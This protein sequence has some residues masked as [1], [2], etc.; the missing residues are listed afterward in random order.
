MDKIMEIRELIYNVFHSSEVVYTHFRGDNYARYYTSMYLIAD[1]SEAVWT[2]MHG[3]FSRDPMRAYIEFWGVMQA[4][5]I[6]QDAICELHK[7]VVGSRPDKDQIGPAWKDLK[8]K[9]NL[10]AGHPAHRSHGVPAPQ[11]TFMGRSFG[12]YNGIK[13]ELWDAHTKEITHPVFDLRKMIEDYDLEASAILTNVLNNMR[14]LTMDQNG[15]TDH[16]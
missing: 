16:N 8:E 4:V 5:A 9:R 3:G 14:R 6:Q 7:A 11:R 12:D 13:F 10:C 1:T 2:H 15:S